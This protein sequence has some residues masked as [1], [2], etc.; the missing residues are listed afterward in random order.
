MSCWIGQAVIAELVGHE[1]AMDLFRHTTELGNHV[2]RHS[3]L[4]L[5]WV[6]CHLLWLQ[7]HSLKK[8]NL[9]QLNTYGLILYTGTFVISCLSV[10]CLSIYLSSLFVSYIVHWCIGISFLMSVCLTICLSLSIHM[11]SLFASPSLMN[12]LACL[13][14]GHPCSL[15]YTCCGPGRI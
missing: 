8:K 3:C 1:D 14:R 12:I 9:I 5:L 2:C 11:S 10:L 6:A 4:H 13:S 7:T 15:E